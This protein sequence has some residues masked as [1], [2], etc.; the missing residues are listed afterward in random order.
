MAVIGPQPLILI[1]I[2]QNTY[3]LLFPLPGCLLSKRVPHTLSLFFLFSS[4][5]SSLFQCWDC[6]PLICFGSGDIPLPSPFNFLS[7]ACCCWGG[8]PLCS[9]LPLCS[10][11]GLPMF[12]ERWRLT[13]KNTQTKQNKQ[14]S[15]HHSSI[16]THSIFLQFC[17]GVA[18]PS[19]FAVGAGSSP[20]KIPLSLCCVL[21]GGHTPL[22]SPLISYHYQHHLPMPICVWEREG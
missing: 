7:R 17:C 6:C 8:P 10:H 20:S 9:G 18:C 11:E 19:H 22:L 5:F 12:G 2:L 14:N 1:P 13:T 3:S 4:L 16:K 15:T 21:T